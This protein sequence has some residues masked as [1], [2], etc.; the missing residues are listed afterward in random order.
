MTETPPEP[1]VQVRPRRRRGLAIGAGAAVLAVVAA[2]AV[3]AT[4]ALSGGGRQP[5]E[6]VPATAFAYLKVDLDPAA[7]QKL[8]ARSFLGKLPKGDSL[9]D[10]I[11]SLLPGG[12]D[13]ERD[14][15]PWFGKRAG[16][17]AFPGAGD[18]V[19]VVA[20]LRSKDDGEARKSLDRVAAREG[21]AYRITDGYAVVGERAA[22]D[23]AVAA[24]ESIAENA[25][26]AAD[27]ARLSGAQVAVGWA[28][29]GRAYGVVTEAFPLA[30][31]L[32]GTGAQGRTVFGVHLTRDYA[33][34]R[35][36]T[37][38][39]PRA[40]APPAVDHAVLRG[41]PADTAL[42][43]SFGGA[44]ELLGKDGAWLQDL[45]AP[46]LVG[47]GLTV[48]DDLL[49]L[50][51]GQT[52]FAMGPFRGLSDLQ[53]GVVTRVRDAGK[54]RATAERVSDIAG[55]LGMPVKA[56]VAGGTFVLATPESYA[57]HLTKGGGALGRSTRFTTAMGDLT[58]ASFALY[59]DV[60][61]VQKAAA[62]FLGLPVTGLS[63]AGLVAG[64]RDGESF[65][66]LRLVA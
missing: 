65:Y 50:L 9:G 57:T 31:M 1:P 39:A 8:A 32:P 49:P 29:L 27:V 26:Y 19:R 59:A 56:E 3:Y 10:L 44:G 6:L 53:A 5:D 62:F 35:G 17:A 30:G 21:V 13:Y 46:Y 47:S 23:E 14:V 37:I 54:A 64:M 45:V 63:A 58:G 24:T 60:R 7:G 11:T 25:T 43:A 2:A 16:V 55:V 61:E 42:A 22:V 18:A 12:L 48:A 51:G 36:L 33:E 40:G 34:M 38:G 15:E 41:L 52:A 66:R 28:D 20:V 4:T